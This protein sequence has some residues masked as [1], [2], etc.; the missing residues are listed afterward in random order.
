[1]K[2]EHSDKE[3]YDTHGILADIIDEDIELTL[4]DALRTEILT[5][6]R[7]RSLKNVSIKID[8]LYLQ[9]IKKIATQKGL[10]YQVLVRQWL[11]EKIRKELKFV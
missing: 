5:G 11:I 1:M 4:D 7:Q 8:S 3:Y 10:P 6:K 9:A 2:T